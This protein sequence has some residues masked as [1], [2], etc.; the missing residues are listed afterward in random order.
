MPCKTRCQTSRADG[1]R[2]RVASHV[3]DTTSIEPLQQHGGL[4]PRGYAY[5]M[6]MLMSG[7]ATAPRL[8]PHAGGTESAEV[9]AVEPLCI[10]AGYHQGQDQWSETAM[11]SCVQSVVVAPGKQRLQVRTARESVYGYVIAF[12]AQAGH[13]Y[14]IIALGYKSELAFCCEPVPAG[15]AIADRTR[16]NNDDP[17]GRP[18]GVECSDPYL[19]GSL[20][21]PWSPVSCRDSLAGKASESRE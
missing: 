9:S 12:D 14:E 19:S 7:C 17:S 11:Y 6:L 5:A 8:Y 20:E 13:R 4:S 21:N 16:R 1:D 10:A 3:H 18:V 15:V 2:V